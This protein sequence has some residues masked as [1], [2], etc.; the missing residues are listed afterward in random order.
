MNHLFSSLSQRNPL[1]LSVHLKMMLYIF[2]SLFLLTQLVFRSSHICECH[3]I[4]KLF[5]YESLLN[6]ISIYL[7]RIVREWACRAPEGRGFGMAERLE[8]EFTGD[9]V[10]GEAG[11][12]ERWVEIES[13]GPLR[14]E[15]LVVSLE[16]ES[17]ANKNS[18]FSL[19]VCKDWFCFRLY[20]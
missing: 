1:W 16:C 13:I 20:T 12:A 19:D 10:E 2:K 18:A 7:R 5:C 3:C 11:V 6:T 4:M 9:A 14:W 8:D 17:L 15:T